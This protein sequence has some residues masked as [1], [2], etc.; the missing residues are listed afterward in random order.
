MGPEEGLGQESFFWSQGG[1]SPVG[2]VR[3]S[4]SSMGGWGLYQPRLRQ[5][6]RSFSQTTTQNT[7]T[8]S[9]SPS[10]QPRPGVP[11]EH[12]HPSLSSRPPSLP[13]VPPVLPSQHPDKTSTTTNRTVKSNKNNKKMSTAPFVRKTYDLVSDP[14]T[15]EIVCWS[16]DGKSFTIRKP[17]VLQTKILPQYF[18]HN[19]LCSLIRQLNT[20]GFRK[21]VAPNSRKDSDRDYDLD[22]DEEDFDDFEDEDDEE[23]ERPSRNK[24]TASHKKKATSSSSASEEYDESKEAMEFRHTH[25]V[26]GEVSSLS[27]V[28]RNRPQKRKSAG[29]SKSSRSESYD[30]SPSDYQQGSASYATQE[31]VDQL[32]QET[33]ML[34]KALIVLSKQNQMANQKMQ[35]MALEIDDLKKR[36]YAE[37][38]S[39]NMNA[40]NS[41]IHGGVVT[42]PNF[43][44]MN[45]QSSY[46]SSSSSSSSSY[47]PYSPAKRRCLGSEEDVDESLLSLDCDDHYANSPFSFLEVKKEDPFNVGGESDWMDLFPLS[48]R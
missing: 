37:H 36:L 35:M 15:D 43:G 30:D 3:S 27:L 42:N 44:N 32:R 10:P 7:T 17:H 34:S 16:K 28:T 11:F 12:Q 20:Y 18:K 13:I 2:L 14:K 47:N 1:L 21:I 46:S 26:R 45:A 31:E 19:N 38:L 4:W 23:D 9:K 24:A 40:N 6:S 41:N 39:S 22:E 48:H 25:F 5:S 29:R 8:Q 33:K